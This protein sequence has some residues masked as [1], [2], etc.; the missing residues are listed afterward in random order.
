MAEPPAP[1]PRSPHAPPG[2]AVRVR[3]LL[4]LVLVVLAVHGLVLRQV[5]ESSMM[6]WGAGRGPA[7]PPIDVRFVR[8]LSPSVAPPVARPVAPRPRRTAAAT[9]PLPAA[10]V[11]S[12]EASQALPP[13]DPPAVAL[14]ASH[15][16]PE[17]PLSTVPASG[18]ESTLAS[19]ATVPPAA[20][21]SDPVAFDWPPSTRLNYSMNGYWRGPLQGSARVEWLR[22]GFRYQ[23]RLTVTIPP[24]FER[25]I[26]SDGLVGPDGLTPQRF[27]QETDLPL[28]S[29]RRETVLFQ[30][31]EVLLVNGKRVPSLPGIQ[32]TASQFVHMTWMFL[33]QPTRALPGRTVDF[34]LAL[35]RRVGRWRYT[36]E[37]PETLSLPFGEVQAQHLRPHTEN[38]HPRE[39]QMDIWIA[40]GL[41]YLPVRILLKLEVEEATLELLLSDKPQQ[42]AR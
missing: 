32:D 14:A 17:A 34:P 30:D 36:V 21:A 2:G 11:P 38:S 22:S 7:P 13:D 12:P 10:S 15:S 42:A 5:L 20:A 25:R 35:P 29:T 9:Q 31:G 3:L 1:G 37:P 6:G 33:T 18:P 16:V 39:P 23:V 26:L 41:Q 8:E 4:A 19:A 24:V 27:D 40:P 28:M